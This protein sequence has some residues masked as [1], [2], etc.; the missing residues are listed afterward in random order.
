MSSRSSE[1]NRCSY[2]RISKCAQI[3]FSRN[4][5]WDLP[6]IAAWLVVKFSGA[7]ATASKRGRT[8]AAA[9]WRCEYR[10]R[11]RRRACR[12]RRSH[13][14][15]KLVDTERRLCRTCR[16]CSARRAS[17]RRAVVRRAGRRPGCRRR[18]VVTAERATPLHHC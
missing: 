5:R 7:A 6:V 2:K 18:S 4:R 11:T 8:H 10:R 17:I 14:A 1:S 15:S 12:G 16:S 3:D 13:A 9:S